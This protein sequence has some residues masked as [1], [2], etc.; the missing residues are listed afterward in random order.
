M[1][2]PQ[3]YEIPCKVLGFA[4]DFLLCRLLDKLEFVYSKE[5]I[6]SCTSLKKTDR[7]KPSATA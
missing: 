5:F 3:P 2:Y 7:W 6:I 1:S 4:R